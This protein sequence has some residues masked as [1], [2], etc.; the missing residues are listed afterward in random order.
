MT[1][2]RT[3]LLANPRGFCAGVSRAIEIVDKVLEKYK[4]HPVYVLHEVV[5]NKH[6]VDDLKNKG[7]IFV[8]HIRDIP[9]GSIVVFSAHGVSEKIVNCA[10]DR[11]LQVF[12]ATCPIVEKVHRKVRRLSNLNEEV[13]MIGHPGHQEVEGTLGQYTSNCGGM[14]IVTSESD[15]KNLKIKSP[16]KLHFVTQTTLSVDETKEC[17]NS[18]KNYFPDIQGPSGHD[19]CYATQNRQIAVKEIA[20]MADLVLVVGSKNS[21]NSN[22]LSEVAQ[23]A[24]CRS[25]LIDDY[26]DLS[27]DMF[28]NVNKVAVTGGASAPEYLINDLLKYLQSKGFTCVQEIGQSKEKQSFKMPD[29]L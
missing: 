25:F 18:L 20:S 26:H 24:G 7:A 2:E 4:G 22:R 19:I 8:E 27:C 5:H 10:K 14:Y 17:I 29:G 21:S 23:K 16:D 1:S 13:I 15:I 9:E 28:K 3:I 6:V 12:D 11:N